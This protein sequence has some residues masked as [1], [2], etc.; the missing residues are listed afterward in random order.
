[1]SDIAEQDYDEL[2]KKMIGKIIISN[3]LAVDDIESI[4]DINNFFNYTVE[5]K[6]KNIKYNLYIWMYP[7]FN[8]ILIDSKYSDDYFLFASRN[9]EKEIKEDII[10]GI[11]FYIKYYIEKKRNIDKISNIKEKLIKYKLINDVRHNICNE[12]DYV[13]DKAIRNKDD[14]IIDYI[15]S[16]INIECKKILAKNRRVRNIENKIKEE[17]REELMPILTPVFKDIIFK[18][19]TSKTFVKET[20]VKFLVGNKLYEMDYDYY[21][22]STYF[23]IRD[24]L[25]YRQDMEDLIF[26]KSSNIKCNYKDGYIYYNKY[27]DEYT[28]YPNNVGSGLRFKI[29]NMPHILKEYTLNF[30]DEHLYKDLT[31]CKDGFKHYS[32]YE[33]GVNIV[34]HRVIIYFENI[35]NNYTIYYYDPQGYEN[36]TST[37]LKMYEHFEFI[38]DCL[39]T[40]ARRKINDPYT[41]KH[42]YTF[43][44][45][46]LFSGCPIGLQKFT[47]NF[48]IGMCQTFTLF[49]LYN[50][51]AIKNFIRNIKYINEIPMSKIIPRIEEYYQ[52]N[53]SDYHMYNLLLSFFSQFINELLN[54]DNEL[55]K[56]LSIVILDN[57]KKEYLNRKKGDRIKITRLNQ[58]QLQDQQ[59]LFNNYKIIIG[60]HESDVVKQLTIIANKQ[61]EEQ[62][63]LFEQEINRT[64][65]IPGRKLISRCDHHEDCSSE[66]CAYSHRHKGKICSPKQF[67]RE[68]HEKRKNRD[69]KKF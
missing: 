53:L 68:I 42:P 28:H 10:K 44:L 24:K 41:F 36:T 12:F 56:E 20:D 61:A 38:T 21:L 58:K 49:W 19:L 35:N 31:K 52:K 29:S 8:R 45:E 66:C 30:F 34:G 64:K 9:I 60:D 23:M 26:S 43:K 59:E 2:L 3:D 57:F 39:N 50:I 63:K 32:I 51:V 4:T 16:I 54:R 5:S 22:R 6:M 11:I 13:L 1:M 65:N 15:N 69:L 48:D 47:L 67:C 18:F 27:F 37:S 17:D 7:V 55:S 62:T 14:E 40:I 25:K 33:E 46:Y